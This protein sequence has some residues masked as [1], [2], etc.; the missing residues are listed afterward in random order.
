M[1]GEARVS[2]LFVQKDIEE[3]SIREI[4]PK[5]TVLKSV[6]ICCLGLLIIT[7]YLRLYVLPGK[8]NFQISWFVP[9]YTG[10][11]LSLWIFSAL[12]KRKRIRISRKSMELGQ[13]FAPPYRINWDD[14][15]EVQL[16]HYSLF[17]LLVFVPQ[18]MESSI[19]LHLTNGMTF[20]LPAHL[21]NLDE[22]YTL[23][24]CCVAKEAVIP[25]EIRKSFQPISF[26]EW[27]EER[28]DCIN[29]V[30]ESTRQ[31]TCEEPLQ[32]QATSSL[33]QKEFPLYISLLAGGVMFVSEYF[34]F[35]AFFLILWPCLFGDNPP[36]LKGENQSLLSFVACFLPLLVLSD[37]FIPTISPYSPFQ[38]FRMLLSEKMKDPRCQD[39]DNRAKSAF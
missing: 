7:V 33:M 39:E 29:A 25:S 19:T 27:G 14:I 15:R 16:K 21:W 10:I 18:K 3:I 34:K 32:N 26:E 1:A 2:G 35:L 38:K 23:L 5:Y 30:I 12:L 9:V 6:G 20:F 28:S 4:Y 31:K 8:E 37:M 24:A 13:I 22:I 11:Y 36:W 17:Q